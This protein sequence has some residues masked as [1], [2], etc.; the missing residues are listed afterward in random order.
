[1]SLKVSMRQL[2]DRLPEL[3]D[4][5]VETGEACVVQRQGKDYA[6]IVSA[7][8]WRRRTVG[9]RLNA[10]GPKYQLS[11]AKQARVEDLLA[12]NKQNR[13]SPAERRKLNRLLL[14]CDGIL[15]R[16]ADALGALA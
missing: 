9:K 8:E 1:M 3:L 7:R 13:L 16:R 14:E 11:R 4:K 12:K 5:A 15:Q 2:Q 6:V 10:L